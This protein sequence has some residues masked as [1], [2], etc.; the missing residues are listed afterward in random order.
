MGS[1]ISVMTPFTL[2]HPAGAPLLPG[3]LPTPLTK[4]RAAA[5]HRLDLCPRSCQEDKAEGGE[6]KRKGWTDLPELSR[7]PLMPPGPLAQPCTYLDLRGYLHSRPA[8]W[9]VFSDFCI[10]RCPP[11]LALH[12]EAC[13]P[14]R[15]WL[16]GLVDFGATEQ[17]AVVRERGGPVRCGAMGLVHIRRRAGSWYRCC[18]QV[19]CAHLAMT[20]LLPL[21]VGR[22]VCLVHLSPTY[23]WRSG[24]VQ[25][26]PCP[27][28]RDSWEPGSREAGTGP[29]QMRGAES[30]EQG[31][32]PVLGQPQPSHDVCFGGE[33]PS[34][35]RE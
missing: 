25:A 4:A 21:S 19:V 14:G 6:E 5:R 24:H 32:S 1:L 15:A 10:P 18:G 29:G 33:S 35:P 22:P 9:G 17:L 26:F 12:P 34:D 28:L 8:G 31:C 27:T 23:P 3:L 13:R 30:K 20:H 16:Q 11:H 2:R 7:P